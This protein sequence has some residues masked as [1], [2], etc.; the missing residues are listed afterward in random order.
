MIEEPEE[1]RRIAVTYD[2]LRAV[3]QPPQRSLCRARLFPGARASRLRAIRIRSYAGRQ[4][5]G[6]RNGGRVEGS[7][8][9]TPFSSAACAYRRARPW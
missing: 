6:I 2:Q 7:R 5:G 3:A 9:D 1:V 4:H 8:R